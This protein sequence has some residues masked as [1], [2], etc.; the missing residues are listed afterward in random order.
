[1]HYPM[2]SSVPGTMGANMEF[3]EL[4]EYLHLGFKDDTD[5]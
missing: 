4:S 1:M 3:L 2:P 5:S